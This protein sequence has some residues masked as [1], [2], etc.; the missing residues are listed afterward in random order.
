MNDDIELGELEFRP[1]DF[2]RCTLKS[3]PDVRIFMAEET[4]RILRE[5][6]GIA[7]AIDGLLQSETTYFIPTRYSPTHTA[8][9]VCIEEIPK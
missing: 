5:R 8:R 1:E 9:I 2:N 6:L 3:R 4:N 7:Q